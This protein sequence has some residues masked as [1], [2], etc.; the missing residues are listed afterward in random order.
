MQVI[1]FDNH[2]DVVQEAGLLE[3]EQQIHADP[4]SPSPNFRIHF[5]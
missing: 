3:V 4:Y 2:V 1:Q 5:L